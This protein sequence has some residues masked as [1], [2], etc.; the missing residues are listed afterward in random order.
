MNSVIG[1]TNLPKRRG[2]C[3]N[4]F[5]NGIVYIAVNTYKL[6]KSLLAI[7]EGW[8]NLCRNTESLPILFLH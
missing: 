2:I 3:L 1:L 7:L 4:T 5:P 8:L 6:R